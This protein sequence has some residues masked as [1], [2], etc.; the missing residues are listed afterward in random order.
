MTWTYSSML[1]GELSFYSR[2]AAYVAVAGPYDVRAIIVSFGIWTSQGRQKRRPTINEK[3]IRFR[4]WSHFIMNLSARTVVT[5]A[6]GNNLS[7]KMKLLPFLFFGRPKLKDPF[8][9][10]LITGKVS[11]HST[12]C[13]KRIVWLMAEENSCRWWRSSSMTGSPCK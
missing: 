11:L 7:A 9:Y 2:S 3:R 12:F 8:G 10:D 4:L 13:R 5:A 6:V 1:P